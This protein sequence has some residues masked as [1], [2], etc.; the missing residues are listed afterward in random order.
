METH[1]DIETGLSLQEVKRR[2]A[3]Y[4]L[5]TLQDKGKNTVLRALL[6][7]FMNPLVIILLFAAFLSL[8]FG[9]RSSFII[10]TT[11][12]LLSTS[13]DFINTF[14]SQKAA[15]ELKAKVR[16][17]VTVI[18][19]SATRVIP[20]AQLV[21]GDIVV[22]SAGKVVPADGVTRD[23]KDL[24]ANESALTGES[25]P[26]TKG[27]GDAVYMGSGVMSGKGLMEVTAIGKETKFAHIAAALQSSRKLT[28]FQR[29][30]RDFS[31]LIVKVTFFLVLFVFLMNVLFQRGI[32]DSLLFSLALAVGL[33]PELLPLII[34]LNLTQG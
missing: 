25:F 27:Q 7:R 16:V 23:S 24:F 10:I 22:L 9:D 3:R 8:F 34:T 11:I 15:D 20:A 4:G 12:V 5:N 30:I 13:L 19:A 29:E 2:R 21:P 26:Q 31:F 33:T 6:A 1:T 28:E 14:R 17:G 18:R 32:L